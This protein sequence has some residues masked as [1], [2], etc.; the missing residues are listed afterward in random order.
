MLNIFGGCS[1]LKS[2][3]IPNSVQSI[4]KS[5]FEFCSN[6]TEVISL[7]TTPPEIEENTFDANTYSKAT[8]K[9]PIECRIIYGQ[10]PYWEN[11]LN[12][13]EID[14]SAIS[15]ITK[16]EFSSKVDGV[17]NLKGER[18]DVNEDNVN[19]LP[20]GIYIVNGKKVINK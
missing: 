14:L 4:G 10:Q 6:L 9:I 18:I 1:G 17:Y 5:A 2:V 20:K 3:I 12:V 7:N 11:F 8:L 19:E 13:E 16:E 15:S